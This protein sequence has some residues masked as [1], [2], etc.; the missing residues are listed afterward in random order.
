MTILSSLCLIL[1]EQRCF[2]DGLVGYADLFM[3]GKKLATLKFNFATTLMC[4]VL[5]VVANPA[6]DLECLLT[7]SHSPKS[8]YVRIEKKVLLECWP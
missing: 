1:K 5:S 6:I 2:C 4:A 3:H 7:P 8:S